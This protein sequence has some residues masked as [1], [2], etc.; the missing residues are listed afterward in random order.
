MMIMK[1]M[2]VM[3]M[4]MVA[5]MNHSDDHDDNDSNYGD[6]YFSWD[7]WHFEDVQKRLKIDYMQSIITPN[8]SYHALESLFTLRAL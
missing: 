8:H 3:M 2:M 7:A 4:L 6:N 1:M 5:M